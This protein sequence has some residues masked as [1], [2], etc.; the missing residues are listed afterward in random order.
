MLLRRSMQRPAQLLAVLA[1]AAAAPACVGRASAADCP[2]ATGACPYS[3][4]AVFGQEGNG[5]FCFPQAVAVDRRGDV[6]VADEYSFVVQRFSPQG[7]F[8]GQFGTFGSD[9]GELGAVG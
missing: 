2:G 5:A 9:P 3:G 1:L 6:Y 4:V 8:L 7:V